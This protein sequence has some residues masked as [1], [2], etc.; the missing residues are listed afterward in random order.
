MHTSAFK[1]RG[2]EGDV[3]IFHNGDWSGEAIIRFQEEVFGKWDKQKKPVQEVE[4][5]AKL[6][7]ALAIPATRAMVSDL[8]VSFAERLPETLG[9][10][11]ASEAAAAEAQKG[12]KKKEEPYWNTDD[13]VYGTQFVYCIQHCR[14]H[15]TGWC[16]VAAVD[17]IALLSTTQKDA[18]MEWDLKKS[19][20]GLGKR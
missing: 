6:L 10:Y 4:I 15:E 19:T 20:L 9:I 18:E 3:L 17:K 5:P 1:I 12:R 11:E 14:V 2:Y 7:A 8:L 16:T 13:K